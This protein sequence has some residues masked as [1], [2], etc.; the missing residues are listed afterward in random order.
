MRLLVI[1]GSTRSGSFNTALARLVARAR[2]DDHV[3]VV[4]DL[5]QL[6][7]FDADVEAASTPLAVERIRTAVHRADALVLVTP[8]YNGTVPGV[9]GNAVDWLSRPHGQSPLISK[10]VVVLSASPSRYGAVRA[11]DH[12]REVLATIGADVLGQGLSLARAHQRLAEDEP[13]VLD[14]LTGALRPALDDLPV[15]AETDAA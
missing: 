14:E 2:P 6:P 13:G 8:E 1:S 5:D 11:A 4:H 12:V 9:L 15:R 3:Q 7:F 10:P